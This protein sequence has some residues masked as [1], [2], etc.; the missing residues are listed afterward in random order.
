MDGTDT[1]LAVCVHDTAGYAAL[2]CVFRFLED[3]RSWQGYVRKVYG[4][5]ALLL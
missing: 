3:A 2:C 1:D 5:F 4:F